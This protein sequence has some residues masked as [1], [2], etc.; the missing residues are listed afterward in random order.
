MDLTYGTEPGTL[1]SGKTFF[2]FSPVFG[3]KILQ[4]SQIARCPTQCKSGP[5]NSMVLGV[6]IHDTFFNDNSPPP[7]QFLCGK[8]VLKK[9][10]YTKGNAR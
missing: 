9:I 7:R 4:K 10:S 2:W 3:K 6:A 8:I 5:G 1:R